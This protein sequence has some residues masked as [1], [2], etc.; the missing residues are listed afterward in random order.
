[1][2]TVNIHEIYV[3]YSIVCPKCGWVFWLTEAQYNDNSYHI[4]CDCNIRMKPARVPKEQMKQVE[5]GKLANELLELVSVL[6]ESGLTVSEAKSKIKQV[7]AEGKD[8][9]TIFKDVMSLS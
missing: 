4:T 7:Y 2:I 3:Q 1:M 6:V 8:L 9:A 5:K